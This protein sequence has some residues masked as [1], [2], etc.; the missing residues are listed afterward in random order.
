MHNTLINGHSKQ[1]GTLKSPTHHS[2][3]VN[4]TEVE[5]RGVRR[6]VGG[7]GMR[8]SRKKG[9]ATVFFYV[10][11]FNLLQQPFRKRE[12]REEGKRG[13]RRMTESTKEGVVIVF[14]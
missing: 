1:I 4:V 2:F 14:L 6:G 11:K 10:E 3:H 8:E 7:G 12:A 13:R 5:V 9:V